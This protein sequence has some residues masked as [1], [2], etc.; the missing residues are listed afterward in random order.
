MGQ[1]LTGYNF[2]NQIP[3]SS[4]SGT[5]WQALNQDGIREAGENGLAGFTFY[6][7]L[8]GD[9]K[10]D[11]GDPTA[12]FEA[13]NGQFVITTNVIGTYTLREV[14]KS[15]FTQTSP[16]NS[17]GYTVTLTGGNTITGD[18]FGNSGPNLDFGDAPDD[19]TFHYQTLLANNGARAYILPG[20]HL[21]ATETAEADG[22]PNLTASGDAGDDGITITQM[23][24]GATSTVTAIVVAPA[25]MSGFL[26]GW[27][28]FRHSDNWNDAEDQIIK[29]KVVGNGTVQITFTVPAD[30]VAG[31]TYARFRLSVE[32]GIGPAGLSNGGEVEDYAITILSG[33]AVAVNDAYTVNENSMNNPLNVLANDLPS[34]HGPLSIISTSVPSNLGTVTINSSVTRRTFLEY[35]PLNG[36]VGTETFT[37]TASDGTGT[38]SGTSTATVTVT[39]LSILHS[40]IA[41]DDDAF[42]PASSFGTP[43][44]VNVL[45]NDFPGDNGP[46]TITSVNVPAGNEAAVTIGANGSNLQ[47]TVPVGSAPTT[48]QFT[49]TVSDNSNPVQTS[50]A[51]VTLHLGNTSANDLV[52]YTLQT[53]DLQGNAITTIQPGQQFVLKMFVQDLRPNPPNT[54][55]GVFAA[56]M[57]LL[58][59]SNLVTITS[60]ITYNPSFGLVHDQSLATPG[61]IDEA[62]GSQGNSSIT[63][64]GSPVMLFSVQLLA[65]QIGSAVFQ[66]D[67]AD[68]HPAHDTLLYN[69]VTVVPYTE[70]GYG[71]TTLTIGNPI[72][73]L[74]Q[75]VNDAY[76]NVSNNS[77]TTLNVT[78]NDFL[79]LN[80][81]V[82]ITSTSQVGT[83]QG[84]VTISSNGQ[85]LIYT[86]V[87]GENGTDQFTYTLTNSLGQ[88]TT[89]TATVFVGNTAANAQVAIQLKVTDTNGNPITTIAQGSQFQVHAYVQDLRT[90][91]TSLSGIAAAWLNVL[92]NYQDATVVTVPTSTNPRGF[93]ITYGAQYQQL[94]SGSANTPGVISEVGAFEGNSSGGNPG[95]L[96]SGQVELFRVT[97]TASGA[98]G[99]NIN[100]LADPRDITPNH[101]V[102]LYNPPSAVP[103]ASISF[104][105]AGL[106]IG[107]TTGAVAAAAFTNP[108]NALDVNNDG[109]ISPLDAL[110]VINMLNSIGTHPLTPA[111]ASAGT[112]RRP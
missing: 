63:L 32:A 84:S 44:T 108:T 34:A 85:A 107:T 102:L 82:T 62:G 21:G 25:G 57:D 79:G 39:V 48:E 101:D 40:P 42:I 1:N 67:P 112:A 65:N 15:G 77:T 36:F 72:Q 35:T 50:T 28:D 49:Y 74:F 105:G 66:T 33:K 18:D 11:L 110:I 96:G 53:F 46:L 38:A 69:P 27:I 12:V 23:I 73:S 78:S 54:Q 37:Y 64:S 88:T 26:S 9:G 19:A 98:L 45:A 3:S 52:S 17:A 93:A 70:I 30:A 29:D 43:Q 111:A 81:P 89:A 2:G 104:V 103:T 75:A 22:K 92:Y 59:Q 56:F 20:F 83:P 99:D 91:A 87:P 5:K 55:L 7:D 94:E 90:P 58:Y 71:S 51:T 13:R 24:A 6:L 106:T 41:V 86:P 95:P 80:G 76:P 47:V 97:F 109:K 4:I 60:P 8:Q 31:T 100:F 61:L 68:I 10:L 16:A 14:P